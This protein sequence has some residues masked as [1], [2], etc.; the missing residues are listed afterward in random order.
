MPR[1]LLGDVLLSGGCITESQLKSAIAHQ[2]KWGSRIG[3]SLVALGYVTEATMHAAL[4]H[5]LGIRLIEIG[6]RIFPRALVD[7]LPPALMRKRHVFPVGL[8]RAQ[9][10]RPGKLVVAVTDPCD[11]AALDEVAFA[12]GVDIEV[13]LASGSDVDR[14]IERHL[15]GPRNRR[16]EAIDLPADPG[17]IE[18]LVRGKPMP[19]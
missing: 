8:R 4:A 13:V 9:G 16:S 5:Q 2:E 11:L 19:R 1:A 18:L 15:D 14:A 12:A 17:P 3:E 6:D 7:L 10:A